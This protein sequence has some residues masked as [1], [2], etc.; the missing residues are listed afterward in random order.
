[1]VMVPRHDDPRIWMGGDLPWLSRQVMEYFWSEHPAGII[2]G[3]GYGEKS[4]RK[5]QAK[6]VKVYLVHILNYR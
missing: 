3:G 4:V 2:G 1:M 6:D 5:K